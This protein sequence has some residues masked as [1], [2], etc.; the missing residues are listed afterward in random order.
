[1]LEETKSEQMND[2]DDEEV[3]EVDDDEEEE[4]ETYHDNDLDC[5]EI[6]KPNLIE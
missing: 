1:L 2:I 3:M 4:N 6:I 5:K